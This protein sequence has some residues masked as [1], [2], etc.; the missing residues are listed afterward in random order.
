MLAAIFLSVLF[1][2]SYIAHHLLAG[3]DLDWKSLWAELSA[4]FA[5][6]GKADEDFKEYVPPNRNLGAIFIKAYRRMKN[7][8]ETKND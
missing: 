7:E 6:K 8:A 4:S 2:L 5:G 3:D 1:L